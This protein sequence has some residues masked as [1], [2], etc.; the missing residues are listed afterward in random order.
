MPQRLYIA[1][2][3]DDESLCRSLARLLHQAGFHAISYQSAE[4]FLSDPLRTHFRCLLVDIQL[5][6]MSGIELHGELIASGDRTPVIYIT[7]FDD[8]NAE[9][10]AREMGSAGFFRK[11]D[12]GTDI[13]EA[14]RRVTAAPVAG[15]RPA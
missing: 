15:G 10:Q 12:A 1:V 9:T 13:L 5:G 14:V 8:P 11:S 2:I 4:E 7:A 6:G 3:D